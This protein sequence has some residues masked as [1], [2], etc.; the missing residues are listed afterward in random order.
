MQKPR[1]LLLAALLPLLGC[2]T[3]I[4]NTKAEDPQ[5]MNPFAERYIKLVLGMGDHDADYVDAYYGPPALRDEVKAAK[6]SLDQ[7]YKD[8]VA[9]RDE[10]RATPVPHD[11]M[12]ALRRTYLT[13]QTE[14]LIARAEMLRGK[15]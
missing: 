4:N 7:I 3:A 12:L 10:L 6:P 14:A 11:E 13:R 15:T 8:A 2:A 5:A 9:L 1:I